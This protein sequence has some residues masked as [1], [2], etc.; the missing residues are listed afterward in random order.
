MI[1][2]SY[3]KLMTALEG[4]E[5]AVSKQPTKPILGSAIASAIGSN[6]LNIMGT[7]LSTAIAIDIPVE[8]DG[9]EDSRFLFDMHHAK[10]F[11]KGYKTLLKK[12]KTDTIKII[13]NPEGNIEFQIDEKRHLV[14]RT[15]DPEMMIAEAYEHLENMYK[16]ISGLHVCLDTERF[17]NAVEKLIPF[18]ASDPFMRNLHTLYVEVAESGPF[19]RLIT[20]DGF[21]MGIY[22]LIDDKISRDLADHFL[23]ERSG[24]EAML[25]AY[26]TGVLG[27]TMEIAYYG[28]YVNISSGN[29]KIRLTVIDAEFPDYKRVLPRSTTTTIALKNIDNTLEAFKRLKTVADAGSDSV[30]FS[31]NGSV[32]VVARCPDYGEMVEELNADHEGTDLEA[33]FNP[34]FLIE[35]LT[36]FKKDKAKTVVLKGSSSDSPFLIESNEL[37]GVQHVVM[38][39][40]LV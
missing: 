7:D 9:Q 23:L 26:K 39:I 18:S 28:T 33:V 20:T 11:L 1:K 12:K 27:Q 15:Y 4:I 17:F 8:N 31:I 24:V 6:R 3:E 30:R 14:M 21:R 34:K 35:A 40:R 16:E 5:K 25:K 36:S 13:H 32:K 19:V 2:V 38:P 22:D 29:T 10:K 37:P